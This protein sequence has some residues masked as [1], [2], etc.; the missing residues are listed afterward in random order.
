MSCT[1]RERCWP[2]T[3]SHYAGSARS[4]P[5]AGTVLVT[6]GT[7][8]LGSQV[9]R[10]LVKRHGVRSLVLTS[11]RGPDAV[12]AGELTRE[13]AALGA[14]V[15]VVAC[16]VADRDELA[17]LVAGI[18]DAQPLTGVVH[19]AGVLDD[20]VLTGLTEEQVG[21][22]LRP[23]VDGAVH[24]DELTRGLDLTAFVLFSGFAGVAGSPGQANY[25]AANAFLD[26]LAHRRRAL[27]F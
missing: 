25:A 2:T 18:P 9:A 27:G 16:D 10:H 20:G 19:L 24:L 8:T 17:A 22:V 1:S 23:K 13:L 21:R 11:R 6:G 3:S 15:S 4:R 14:A 7:G 5:A 12:G 26:A